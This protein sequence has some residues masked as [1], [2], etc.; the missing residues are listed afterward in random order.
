MKCSVLHCLNITAPVIS[1][2]AGAV[3][4]SELGLVKIQ[5]VQRCMAILAIAELLF[6]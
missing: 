4:T 2:L 1:R 6:N 5:H 3:L